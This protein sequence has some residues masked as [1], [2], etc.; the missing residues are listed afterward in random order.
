MT[1]KNHK[2]CILAYSTNILSLIIWDHFLRK[3]PWEA[4]VVVGVDGNVGI[5]GSVDGAAGVDI[6]NCGVDSGD[7]V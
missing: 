7:G 2:K 3:L 5:V 6:V 1:C 4:K